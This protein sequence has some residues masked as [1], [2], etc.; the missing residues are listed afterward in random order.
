[1]FLALAV[2]GFALGAWGLTIADGPPEEITLGSFRKAFAAP[3]VYK[4]AVLVLLGGYL[5]GVISVLAPLRLANNL[6]WGAGGIAALFLFSAGAQALINPLLG[7]WADRRGA[8]LPLQLG[9][10]LSAAGSLALA[11]ETGRW[12]YGRSPSAPTWPSG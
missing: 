11:A 3:G 8:H 5:L 2:P 10:A 4:P 12:S 9:L 1:V 7:R 6:H